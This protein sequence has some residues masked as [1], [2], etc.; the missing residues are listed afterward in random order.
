MTPPRWF[1]ED[2]RELP[3]RPCPK[4]GRVIPHNR[5]WWPKAGGEQHWPYEVFGYVTWCGHLQEVVLVPRDDGWFGEI[6]VLGEA[7]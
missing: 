3:T 4:C 5:R 2:G 6:P 1:D 7:S